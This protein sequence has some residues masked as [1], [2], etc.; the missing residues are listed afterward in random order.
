MEFT[1]D[2]AGALDAIDAPALV[3]APELIDYA[4]YLARGGADPAGAGPPAYQ[5]PGL[6]SRADLVA[7]AAGEAW[8]PAALGARL[9]RRE[10]MFFLPVAV[11][12]RDDWADGA[13][14]YALHLFG[15]LPS[16]A[17]AHV[18]VRGVRVYVDVRVPEGAEPQAF[19]ARLRAASDWGG[20]PP[21]FEARAAYPLVGYRR[22]PAAWVRL[23][24][25]DNG[26]RKRAIDELRALGLETASDAPA[27]YFR[28]A[29]CEHRLVLADWCVLRDYDYAPGGAGPPGWGP[30]HGLPPSPL[31][32]HVFGVAADALRPLVTPYLDEAAADSPKLLEASA[33]RARPLLARDRT[34]VLTWDTE[35]L[36][37]AG[38]G[39]GGRAGADDRLFMVGATAHWRAE[40][41]PLLRVCLVDVPTAPDPRWT[42]VVCG[43][44]A[45]VV[46]ALAALL[47]RLAP[48]VVAGFNDGGFD[49]P[50]VLSV[51]ERHGLLGYLAD[52][53]S[54]NP[55]RGG[56]PSEADARRWQVRRDEHVKIEADTM[57]AVTHLWVPGFVPL[58]VS[59]A[60]RRLYPKSEVGGT[61]KLDFYLGLCGLGLKEEMPIPELFRIYRGADPAQMRRA[62]LYCVTDALRCQELLVRRDVVAERR[63]LAALA[64]VSLHDALYRADG[65]KVENIIRAYAAQRG[66]VYSAAQG[67]YEKGEKYGGAYVFPPRMGL[68]PDPG[69]P[70]ARRLEAARAALLAAAGAAVDPARP[71][72]AALAAD[73][74]PEAAG[75]PGAAAEPEARATPAALAALEARHPDAYAAAAAAL[76]GL[77]VQPPVV[78]LDFVSLYPNII[79]TYNLSPDRYVAT[80]AEAEALAADGADLYHV[81]FDY[82]DARREGWFVR[83]GGDPREY[84]LYVH[85]L[86]L[87]FAVRKAVKA[88]Q[89]TLGGVAER[90]A[91][92]QARGAGAPEAFAAAAA[93]LRAAAPALAP[94]VEQAAAGGAPFAAALA[95]LHAEACF[96]RDVLE[97]KQKALKVVMNTFYGKAGQRGSAL[98]VLELAVAV[99]TEGQRAIRLVA[100]AAEARGF[101]VVYGDT[102]SA[103]LQ[104]P[105][106]CL[107]RV[108]RAYAFGFLDRRA[109]W[110]R[111]VAIAMA[112]AA[113]AR[114]ELN[115]LLA[116]E[117]GAPFLR[118]A[119]E[120]VLYPVALVGKK[121]YFGVA[122][123]GAVNFEPRRLFVRGVESEKRGQ[124]GYAKA[125]A[126]EVMRG[127]LAVDNTRPLLRVVEDALLASLAPGRWA[128][129]DF[130]RTATWRPDRQNPAVGRFV[131][132]LGRRLA[133]A[134]A[135]GEAP[136]FEAPAPHERFEYV[137]VRPGAAF[138]LR[139]R[140]VVPTVGD[141]MELAAVARGR[142][143]AGDAA[144]APDFAH[145]LER[146]LLGICARFAAAAFVDGALADPGARDA[147]ALAAAAAHLRGLVRGALGGDPRTL[148]QQGYAYKRAWKEA[149]ATC[150]A[151]A[152]RELGP[153]AALVAGPFLDF[154]DLLAGEAFDRCAAA[155]AAAAAARSAAVASVFCAGVLRRLA[156]APDGGDAGPDTPAAAPAGRLYALGAWLRRP[157]RGFDAPE[158]AARCELRR[159]LSGAA[160]AAAA[161][162][163]TVETAVAAARR[164]AHAARPDELGPPD[165]GS[166]LETL[167]GACGQ[168]GA[169]GAP[170]RPLV[171]DAQRVGLERFHRAWSALVGALAARLALEA[172]A[173]R[174]TAL[175]DARLGHVAAPADVADA[176]EADARRLCG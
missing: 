69:E 85:V 156:I 124:P 129:D 82:D 105:P 168:P 134:A 41:A 113:R 40:A 52:G 35:A 8:G 66:I 56:A 16:G 72:A 13:P 74:A 102:D 47:H 18:V 33:A 93:G 84:G 65:M 79:C 141:R 137:V 9:A 127:A 128:F 119:Y 28:A 71:H 27:N 158:G 118:L 2:A 58:D 67:D 21:R 53:A 95:A 61:A 31:C 135:R 62:A 43:S 123:E 22:A 75:E 111:Y 101:A 172:L 48:D 144:A 15:P 44:E 147:A 126:G 176:I 92:V 152:R 153:R 1:A 109:C 60:F 171:T 34:L 146:G 114:D 59:V 175:K 108:T 120:E 89:A 107:E 12:E 80:R 174:V 163:A 131:E 38:V 133:A 106:R 155:A 76:E 103:Y 164:R 115:A 151:R 50:F 140:R 63:E 24:F 122:H 70:S 26:S 145:Y 10:P 138:D 64:F 149:A 54:A 148:Q 86:C 6:P 97:K 45:G 110:G 87:I 4:G 160:D 112:E 99:T 39:E 165:A 170:A 169:G 100:G 7:A 57:A 17:K 96:R 142:L 88:E 36:C 30:R 37:P 91:L 132:R 51:A 159:L 11:D 83:H 42:T 157:G 49:W 78:G 166:V 5:I 150:A 154:E 143:A 25:A 81:A 104:P 125:V 117:S 136:G 139:G 68:V 46:R 173:A 77:A 14:A 20:R 23:H 19:E 94:H 98:F 90:V 29:A 32:E 73:G 116:R 130:V 162:A 167:A 121:K 161:Y 55:R 3:A